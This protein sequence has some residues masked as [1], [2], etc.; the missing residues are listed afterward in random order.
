MNGIDGVSRFLQRVW[1]LIV[2]EGT[3]R[4][5]EKIIDIPEQSDAGLQILLHRTTK[6]V[7]ESIDS[8]DKMNTAVSRLMEFN[9][10]AMQA[11]TLPLNLIKKF[12][13]LLSPF[14]PHIGE[15]LWRILGEQNT[16]AY[17]EWPSYDPA[18][19]LDE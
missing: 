11:G 2:D 1:R 19:I 9:N 8:I 3:G 6:Q 13:L 18:L 16:V 14:A 5:S 7:T 12:V 15:E 4:L 17:A 10:A